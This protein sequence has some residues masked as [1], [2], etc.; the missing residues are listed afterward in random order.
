VAASVEAVEQLH[1]SFLGRQLH[2]R[3]EL[4]TQRQQQKR[5]H[6]PNGNT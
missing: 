2:K 6:E 1:A 3:A 4:V 5:N